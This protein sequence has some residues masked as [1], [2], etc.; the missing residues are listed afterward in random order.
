M[1]EK[2]VMLDGWNVRLINFRKGL[3][4]RP[5]IYNGIMRLMELNYLKKEDQYIA[6]L[7]KTFMNDRTI[8]L[9]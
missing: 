1:T 3:R 2:V 8:W 4:K 9:T 5:G 6:F 7:K